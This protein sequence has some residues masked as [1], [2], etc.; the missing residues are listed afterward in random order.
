MN[1]A[2]SKQSN[3]ADSLILLQSRALP[4]VENLAMQSRGLDCM[5][6]DWIAALRLR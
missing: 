4:L 6:R 5:M 1:E 3:Q 2:K